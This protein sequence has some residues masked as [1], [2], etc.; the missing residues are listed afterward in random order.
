MSQDLEHI[1]CS[2]YLVRGAGEW[3]QGKLMG[4]L[5]R[6]GTVPIVSDEEIILAM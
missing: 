4:L 6:L 3:V 5:S 2:C 1:L